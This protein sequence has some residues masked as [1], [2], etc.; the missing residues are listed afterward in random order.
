M[1]RRISAPK[2]R[3]RPPKTLRDELLGQ[4]PADI[5]ALLLEFSKHIAAL[6][7][8]Y[9]IFMARKS[10]RLYD[11]LS[12]AGAPTSE[13]PVLSDHVLD[14]SL[15]VFRDKDI[16]LID[17]TLILGTT[18]ADAKKR[19]L[20]AGAK[21]VQCHV[22]AIDAENW[23]RELIVPDKSFAQLD[24]S[25]MLTFCA[26]EVFALSIG[27]IPYLSDFPFSEPVRLTQSAVL[28]LHS[29][30]GWDTHT[31]T[32]RAQEA[33]GVSYYTCLPQQE[34]LEFFTAFLGIP[35][36]RLVELVKVRVFSRRAGTA[37]WARFIP[38]L[39]LRPME[40]RDL[41][42][43]FDSVTKHVAD[44]AG[45][46]SSAIER[47]CTSPTSKLRALQ[48]ALS[49]A[50][51]AYFMS[52]LTRTAGLKRVPA[53]DIKEGV[54][55]FGPWM[56]GDVQE[57]HHAILAIFQDGRPIVFHGPA[58]TAATLPESVIQISKS[59]YREF[60]EASNEE[61]P[62]PNE[63]SASRTRS[64]LTDL[65]R[66]FIGLYRKYEL[67]AREEVHRLG[68]SILTAEAHD[69]P[70]RERLKFGFA[71][72][73][74]V[75][76]M[77]EEHKLKPYT[78]RGN[79]LSLLLDYLIDMGIAVPVLALRDGILFRA[80]RYGEDVPFGDQECALCYEVANGFI[81]AS[82]RS[83]IPRITLEK[84]IVSLMR[85]G[86]A[87]EFLTVIHGPSGGEGIARIGFHL[88]GAVPMMPSHDTL[89]ADEQESWLSR[90]LVDRGVLKE[91]IKARGRYRLYKLG[92]R[93]EASFLKPN[94]PSEA[95]QLGWLLGKLSVKADEQ[96][97]ILNQ[98]DLILL[99]TCI[100]P[101]DAAC[102]IAAE[103][104]LFSSWHDRF[105]HTLQ[106]P[107]DWSD[108]NKLVATRDDFVTGIGYLAIHSARLKIVGYR[109][110]SANEIIEKCGR[111]L[112][113]S[114]NGEFLEAAWQ[115]SWAA[116]TAG[117]SKEQ[118]AQF[119]PS[120][121][122][123]EKY[124]L[125]AAIGAFT[126]EL[127]LASGIIEVSKSERAV[128]DFG[129]ACA[130]IS[131]YLTAFQH[132]ALTKREK[133]VLQR[134][135]QKAA[136]AEPIQAMADSV[137]F[138]LQWL[139]ANVGNMR[140]AANGVEMLAREFGK[141]DKRT[142]FS[143]VLWYDIIDST[144]QKGGLS[145]AELKDYRSR[146]RS[147]KAHF[148]REL[149]GLRR[150]AEREHATIYPWQGLLT[151]RNDEKHIFL[152]GVRNIEWLYQ[153]AKLL[154]TVSAAHGVCVRAVAIRADFAGDPASKY[155]ASPEVEGDSF[156]EH[157][158]RL[159]AKLKNIELEQKLNAGKPPLYSFFWL[160]GNLSIDLDLRKF[161]PWLEPPRRYRVE[162]MI[163]NVRVITAVAGGAVRP[164]I[165]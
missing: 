56:Y 145:G 108:E 134:L 152:T 30:P 29:L 83:D 38:L 116:V 28:T 132:V 43:L 126:I 55:L 144:G 5:A 69:A 10:L 46:F 100:E 101:K 16:I 111:Y 64:L 162:T 54:R 50:V 93:P 109:R 6:K 39:T 4:F 61:Q 110:A 82:G 81:Q 99:A 3:I 149:Y 60:V 90:Y 7:C 105:A 159:T 86:V 130:K 103:L 140:A 135:A 20:D 2:R 26:R 12:A 121:E 113:S 21:S 138:G 142:K 94:A 91:T 25:R 119:N 150:D 128:R 163:E 98:N 154:A 124:A 34:T 136:D 72:R 71:W 118:E 147:F 96:G 62:E 17:D 45:G 27:A 73:A 8:D 14:Q 79:L 63:L 153:A 13:R 23:C 65:I 11:L 35:V 97:T 129:E 107:I 74:L 77:L 78:R 80:Y 41:D 59:E 125:M 133:E 123:L 148:N 22:F 19:L 117:I 165:K 127:S 102:A 84:L 76:V 143:A 122:A 75:E 156:W 131:H 157:L 32:T 18:L 67:P 137:R 57:L 52:T 112:A 95:R 85:V 139:N 58:P 106:R 160:G 24:H 88:H 161:A 114:V 68:S 89:F 36:A 104:K 158:S 15:H 49:L 70:F 146:V 141:A 66:A 48:Y 92:T 37:H 155:S 1:E 51:G 33:A 42:H 44:Q 164:I 151:S 120:I 40:E 87:K 31:L 53:F 115:G 9:L 47:W